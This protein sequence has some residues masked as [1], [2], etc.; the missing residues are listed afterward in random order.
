M[1]ASGLQS[2]SHGNG[3]LKNIVDNHIICGYSLL[4]LVDPNN[5]TPIGALGQ[6]DN[7]ATGQ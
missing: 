1:Q 4:I 3:L 7:I 6:G 5:N 2:G